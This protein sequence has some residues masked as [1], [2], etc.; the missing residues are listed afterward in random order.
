MYCLIAAE[1]ETACV[2]RKSILRMLLDRS[3]QRMSLPIGD[4]AHLRGG[5]AVVRALQCGQLRMCVQLLGHRP[6]SG[7]IISLHSRVSSVNES[8]K[9]VNCVANVGGS[10]WIINSRWWSFA[11]CG[12]KLLRHFVDATLPV[13]RYRIHVSTV[14][15][16]SNI[17]YPEPKPSDWDI[18]HVS[19]GSEARSYRRTYRNGVQWSSP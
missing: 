4:D 2:R 18:L 17:D 6:C 11:R 14:S 3:D 15:R 16:Q 5:H 19:C 9:N 10:C 7:R 8:F 13:E 12:H 1:R